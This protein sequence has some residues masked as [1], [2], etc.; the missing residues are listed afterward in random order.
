V[1]AGTERVQNP[2]QEPQVVNLRA[3]R[4]SYVK[5]GKV[6]NLS[7]NRVQRIWQRYLRREWRMCRGCCP[8]PLACDMTGM[9]IRMRWIEMSEKWEAHEYSDAPIE[10][11]YVEMMIGV[12]K[13]LD[14]TF[15]EGKK[16]DARKIG[17]IL[18]VFPFG[19]AEGRCNYIS[20]G[21]RRED[22]VTMLKEQIARFE[23]QAEQSGRA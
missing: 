5:I 17:F 9:T 6:M 4:L 13:A 18:L 3:Q 10:P 21:A 12:A 19:E 8:E 1:K 20:N 16:G 7:P 15:N 2:E 22:V 14:E 11:A 23:G